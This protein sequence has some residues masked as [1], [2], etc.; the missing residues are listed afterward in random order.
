MAATPPVPSSAHPRL[1]MDA[2][3]L[4]AYQANAKLPHTSAA[5]L[6]DAC[7]NTYTVSGSTITQTDTKSYVQGDGA[8]WAGDALTCAFAYLATGNTQYLDVALLYWQSNLT[9]FA[10]LGDKGGCIGS[11]NGGNRNQVVQQDDGYNMRWY[12]PYTALAY[13]WLY[14]QAPATLLAQTRTCLTSWI[15]W[16][17]CNGNTTDGTNKCAWNGGP[18]NGGY[19]VENPGSNYHAGFFVAKAMAAVALGNDGAA[20]GA[21]GAAGDA[22]GHLWTQLVTNDF[23][24][25]AKEGILGTPQAPNIENGPLTP[26]GPGP[27]SGGDWGE[28]WEYGG[29]SVLEYAAAASAVEAF[30]GLD[31]TTASTINAW[32]NDVAVRN[33]YA[34]VPSLDGNWV[35][36][37]DGDSP[38]YETPNLNT[39]D[40][41]LIGPTSAS[42]ASWTLAMIDA[43]SQWVTTNRE[44]VFPWNAIAEGQAGARGVTAS[45][46]ASQSPAPAL[47]YYADGTRT[48]YVRSA[49][50]SSAYWGV[51]TS[52]PSMVGD[53]SH[54][55]AGN[56]VFSRGA[57]DLV[58]DPSV[59]DERTT[60]ETNAIGVDWSFP[61]STGID[62]SDYTPSQGP[63]S[64]AS[65]PWKRATADGV[66]A[67]R[68]DFAGAFNWESGTKSPISYAHREWV[69]LPEGE[70]V[71]I[72]RVM[73]EGATDK[74]Y[75][76]L[77]FNTGGKGAFPAISGASDTWSGTV[78]GSTVAL[79]LVAPS[80]ATPTISQPG[81]QACTN[82]HWALCTDGRFKADLYSLTVPGPW[83]VAIHVIDG[84][85]KGS[86]LAT[87][88]S[89]NSATYDPSQ[90]NGDVVGAAVFAGSKQ[91]YVV[92]SSAK[93]GASPTTMTY[94]VPG[95]S[96]G[97]HVVYDAPA[98]SD[99]TSK[100]SAAANGDRCDVTITAGSG[101]GIAGEPLMFT[102]ATSADGCT[103]T[104]STD[105]P[106]GKAP[107]GNP[108]E[109]DGG[110]GSSSGSGS[111]SGG[112]SSGSS[113]SGSG[114]SGGADGGG[115]G[116]SPSAPGGK[117]SC[118]CDAVG[119][120]SASYGWLGVAAIA[121][122]LSMRRRS[123]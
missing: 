18:S 37:D 28:G 42:V 99:G 14:A 106:S 101:S 34:T 23:P 82:S 33:I 94:G 51:F 118:A 31:A 73:T 87:V 90:Q 21:T 40:V 9:D 75:V 109:G 26:P 122:G 63:F 114:S 25:L 76:N 83:A 39:L 5:S 91:T 6:V 107:P 35:G 16:Y 98:A 52:S 97:R 81:D 3:S 58:V 66:Y 68:S 80:G 95:A 8:Y 56:F 19:N 50:S 7:Q 53:H 108:N 77:H 79:H 47:W 104:A 72:D 70:V 74:M 123:R 61:S 65:M 27:M 2:K 1:F 84:V 45:P 10:T 78:G 17:D 86:S 60:L 115:T 4:A 22:D 112:G 69:Q 57:D 102:V 88:G 49:W 111:S 71:L 54:F 93:S 32:V 96:A 29:L 44:T 116:D 119:G 113:S 20:G 120:P 100:V 12:A 64:T 121:L 11:A 15:D 46:Y 13:D 89:I 43:Q 67:A 30:D 117:G 55:A 41:G 103:V 105:V 110:T 85:A 48:M 59:Y 62:T 92:A 38:V 24:A 36:G